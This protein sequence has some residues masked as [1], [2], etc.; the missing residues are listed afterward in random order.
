M[1]WY[2]HEPMCG[3]EERHRKLLAPDTQ[4]DETIETDEKGRRKSYHSLLLLIA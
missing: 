4:E 1:S 3:F 2:R